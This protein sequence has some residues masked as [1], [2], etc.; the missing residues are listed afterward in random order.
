MHPLFFGGGESKVEQGD[1]GLAIKI[2][3]LDCCHIQGFPVRF[4]G[5]FDADT[6]I[7]LGNMGCLGQ[8]C[9]MRNEMSRCVAEHVRFEDNSS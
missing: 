7:E 9:V 1:G 3:E 5:N 2:L 4:P 8:L 6:H